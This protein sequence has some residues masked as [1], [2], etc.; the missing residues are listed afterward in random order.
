METKK[1]RNDLDM[2]SMVDVTFLLLIFFMV[3]ASFA[4]QKIQAYPESVTD[5]PSPAATILASDY[6]Q[7]T[8]DDRDNY[9]VM[10]PLDGE[11]EAPSDNEMRQLVRRG[12][13]TSGAR[14]LL[15]VAHVDS[16]HQKVVTALDAGTIAGCN[17]V[18]IKTTETVL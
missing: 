10:T 1:Q 8:I 11:L 12:V 5:Q 13:E 9:F 2:T 14:R 6:V 16:T 17:Q 3:T 18:E 15:V 7:V 4:I